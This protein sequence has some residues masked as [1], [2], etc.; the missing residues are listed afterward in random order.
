MGSSSSSSSGVVQQRLGDRDSGPLAR[1]QL[2]ER[3]IEELGHGEVVRQLCD[4]PAHVAQPVKAGVDLQVFPHR[5]ALGQID[6]GRREVDPRQGPE[7]VGQHVGVEDAHGARRRQQQPE[8][9][10]QGGG[11]SRAVPAQEG[12]DRW[13]GDVEGNPVDRRDLVESLGQRLDL[14]DGSAHGANMVGHRPNDQRD[15]RECY[16]FDAVNSM[17]AFWLSRAILI[18]MSGRARDRRPKSA[19]QGPRVPC[20]GKIRP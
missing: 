4:L 1:R 7:P 17:H 5:E 13:F 3:P 12:D 6:I 15:C 19:G 20:N 18:R 11:L 2:P 10:R 14:D 8:Q 16:G 9:H